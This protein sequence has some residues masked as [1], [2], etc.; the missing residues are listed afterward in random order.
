MERPTLF[1]TDAQGSI[2]RNSLRGHNEQAPLRRRSGFSTRAGRIKS[3]FSAQ[4]PNARTKKRLSAGFFRILEVLRVD[5][6]TP[7]LIDEAFIMPNLALLFGTLLFALGPIFYFLNEP[8]NRSLTALIPVPIGLLIIGA[9]LAARHPARRKAAMHVAAALGL[10]GLLG[11]L[12][13]ARHWPAIFSGNIAS[14][15]RPLAAVEQLLMF[16]ICT[17]FLILCVRS[18]IAARRGR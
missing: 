4:S 10:L 17:T 16:L 6:F 15:A 8:G 12:M 7:R 2:A 9:G 3:G 13:G 11:S 5:V 1:A 18:F 14:L